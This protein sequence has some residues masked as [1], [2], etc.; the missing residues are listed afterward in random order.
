LREIRSDVQRELE[1]LRADGRIGASLQAQVNI[2]DSDLD[3]EILES[4]GQ[5]LKFVLIVSSVNV[6]QGQGEL[7]I[8]A[9]PS[10]KTK[11][12]RCWHYTDDVG[13]DSAHPE[14]CARC[15]A[16]LTEANGG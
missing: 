10:E 7:L 5:A 9:S 13:Q 16:N 8:Q 3:F 12:G 1:V 11:C 14:I 6:T 2:S 4:L 15:V